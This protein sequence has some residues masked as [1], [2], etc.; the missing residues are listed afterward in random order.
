ML[1]KLVQAQTANRRVMQQGLIVNAMPVLP[2]SQR[3]YFSLMDRVRDKVQQ[4]LRH[5]KSF[6]EPDG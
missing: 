5:V 3:G 4:P 1:R 6:M 2:V